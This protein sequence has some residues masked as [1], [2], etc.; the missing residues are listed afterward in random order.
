LS[1]RG[2]RSLLL[3]VHDDFSGLLPVTRNLFPQADVQLCIVHMQRNAK[4]HLSKADAAEFT[5]RLRALKSAWN[6]EVAVAQFEDLCQHLEP[7]SSVFIGEIRKKAPALPS[8]VCRPQI[9]NG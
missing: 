1:E 3:V 5:Q 9:I 4:S 8:V 7:R 6:G 2:L